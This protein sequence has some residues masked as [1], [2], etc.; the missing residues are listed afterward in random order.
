M[1][2]RILGRGRRSPCRQDQQAYSFDVQDIVR[3]GNTIV[4]TRPCLCRAGRGLAST[5]FVPDVGPIAATADET[6]R[7]LGLYS[8]VTFNPTPTLTITAGASFDSIELGSAKEDAVNPKLG[9]VWRP[10]RDTTIR[11][12]AFKTCTTI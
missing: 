9:V 4:Q 5:V 1:L 8:Y 11:T 12:A 2:S 7:Q 10:T 6:N 3:I